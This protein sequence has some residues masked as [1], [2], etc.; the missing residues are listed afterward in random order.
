MIDPDFQCGVCKFWLGH[1]EERGA[2][3]G[4]CHRFPPV[5]PRDEEIECRWPIVR[6]DEWCGECVISAEFAFKDPISG[7]Q[8][9]DPITG[10]ALPKS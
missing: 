8:L 6:Y 7:V 4:E 1:F 3:V 10:Q 5:I 2:S 9:R